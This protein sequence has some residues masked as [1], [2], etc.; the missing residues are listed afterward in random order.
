MVDFEEVKI[1]IFVP[2]EYVERM[3]DELSQVNAG[4]IGNYDHCISVSNVR[5]YWRPLP[6][7]SPYQG[8][9]GKISSGTECKIEINCPGESVD[10]ALRVIRRI[11][12]YDEPLINIV[13]LLNHLYKK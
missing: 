3:R 1:E 6:G 9:I 13:P 12:P 2:E 5:G 10:D 4:H 8:E 7:A 11:H